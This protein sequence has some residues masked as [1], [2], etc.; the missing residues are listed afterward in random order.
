MHVVTVKAHDLFQALA[1]FTRVRIIHLLAKTDDEVCLCELSDALE[2]PEYKLSRHVKVLRQAGLL[3]STKEGR[4]IY[5]RL[6]KDQSHLKQ[7]YQVVLSLPDPD[8]SLL[9]DLRK[10]K[11]RIPLREDGRCRTD[12]KGSVKSKQKFR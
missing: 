9:R 10:F 3:S 6:V 1:D 5:H 11:R 12:S 7:L 4:W 8:H 2:E